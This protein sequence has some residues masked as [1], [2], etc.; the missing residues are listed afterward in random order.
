MGFPTGLFVLKKIFLEVNV[1]VTLRWK[2][3]Q[4][5]LIKLRYVV[6]RVYG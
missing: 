2:L 3:R 5:R 6:A 1:A 4:L